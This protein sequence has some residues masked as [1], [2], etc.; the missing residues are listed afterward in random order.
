MAYDLVIKNGS[1][2]DGSGAPAFKADIAVSDG[3][4]ALI[5]RIREN[6]SQTIDAE[7]H[8]VTPGFIDG[9]TH[10]DAQIF[11]DRLGASSCYHGV[12]SV[13]MGNC[14]FTL[15]PCKE[16]NADFAIRNL[17]RAEDIARTSME[18]GIK[19]SW[20]T[21]P[22]YL[23]ALEALPKG[24]NY[25]GYIG[26]SALRTYV[27]GER[28]FTEKASEDEIVL[29]G[30][31]VQDAVRAGAIGFSTSRTHL[32]FNDQP[33]ASA[34]ADW[35]EV[36]SIVN[37]MGECGTGVFELAGELW[38][39][40]EDPEKNRDY[41]DRLKQLSIESGVPVTWGIAASPGHD[42]YW[43]GKLALLDDV[44][45]SGGRMFAQAHSRTLDVL[46]SF[47]A[48]TP[49]DTWDH[50]RELRALP[51]EEQKAKLRDPA[52]RAKLVEISTNPEGKAFRNS[53][54]ALSTSPPDWDKFLIMDTMVDADQRPMSKVAAE[55]GIT[56]TELMI[57]L[58]LETDLKQLW[59]RPAT[60]INQ[61]HV[62]EL[63]KH[64]HTVVTASD[65][66]AHV[67]QLMDSSLQ[68]SVFSDWVRERQALTIEQAVRL[69]TYDMSRQWGLYNRGLLRV[70][71]AADILVFDPKTIG[72]RLPTVESDLPADE[73]RFKQLSNGI[74][75]T[76]VNGQVMLQNNEH[77]GAQSGQV[78]RGPLAQAA[79]WPNP[80][81]TTA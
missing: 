65:S 21:Y 36:R 58:A 47:E 72:P 81:T 62:L 76:I 46:F 61:D 5:G 43:H 10:M 24:I 70:G 69:V 31:I 33:V 77:T 9:H 73:K 15:A 60:N 64:P 48:R 38:D 11:W 2:I 20:E 59:R 16:E 54:G 41:H 1:I 40:V 13:V 25:A 53:F 22:D 44:A 4:I 19:W 14:G 56:P 74:K 18:Q 34:V 39:P 27:M 51:I 35:D 71:L 67:L 6:G 50:W 8:A 57:D 63:M 37:A 45:A 49:F 42:E 55:K 52:V 12:T 78:L 66:G 23:N 32:L 28:A 7:G 75:A 79:T 80:R 17:E 30:R 3:K 26:H 29:M 68:T